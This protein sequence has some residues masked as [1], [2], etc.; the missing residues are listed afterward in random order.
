MT[1]LFGKYA[2]Y[3]VP[4]YAISA[5]CILAVIVVVLQAYRTAK[6]RLAALESDRP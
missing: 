5:I 2:V 1:A 6:A 4:A 3:V